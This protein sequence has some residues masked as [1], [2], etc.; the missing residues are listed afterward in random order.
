MKKTRQDSVIN[1]C[2]PVTHAKKKRIQGR[3]R[4]NARQSLIGVAFISSSKVI[5]ILYGDH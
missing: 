3:R 4:S 1:P 5:P 2:F